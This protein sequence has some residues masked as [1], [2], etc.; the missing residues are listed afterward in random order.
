MSGPIVRRFV[1]PPVLGL[2]VGLAAA[3]VYWGLEGL[4]VA[5]TDHD[6][7]LWEGSTIVLVINEGYRLS[8]RV[9]RYIDAM[10]KEVPL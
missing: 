1:L 9:L 5:C 8:R 6:R 10:K 3:A 2:A 4:L 7:G